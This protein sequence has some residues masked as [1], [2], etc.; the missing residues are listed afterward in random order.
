MYLPANSFLSTFASG[1]NFQRYQNMFNYL[2]IE[3][4]SSAELK[5]YKSAPAGTL[6]SLR[7][8]VLHPLLET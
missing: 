4:I 5:G 2:S 3:E 7:L 6:V 1:L 8:M